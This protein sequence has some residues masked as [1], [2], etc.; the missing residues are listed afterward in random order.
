MLIE[1]ITINLSKLLYKFCNYESTRIGKQYSNLL[2]LMI[3]QQRRKSIWCFSYKSISKW[4]H[5]GILFSLY[6]SIFW[7]VMKFQSLFINNSC[8]F[9]MEYY[10]TECA[11]HR[12]LWRNNKLLM[13]Q[14]KLNR[15]KPKH[16][17]KKKK[18]TIVSIKLNTK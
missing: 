11:T 10:C 16:T 15:R 2:S 18:K 13:N 4:F 8:L 9:S 5:F 14:H 17:K 12:K 3:F 7:I 6:I 1:Q